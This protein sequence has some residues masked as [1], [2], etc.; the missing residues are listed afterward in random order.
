M[1][2]ISLAVITLVA[3]ESGAQSTTA[4]SAQSDSRMVIT[5][6]SLPE[7]YPHTPYNVRLVV[8]GGTAPWH[9]N[10]IRGAL[11][12]G[13]KLEEDGM[14]HGAAANGGDFQFTVLVRDSGGSRPLATKDFTLHVRSALSL[15]WKSVAHVD[16][17]R[18]EGSAEVSNTSPDDIDLTFIVMAVAA[19]GRA[20]A[21]GYQHF[22]LAKGTISQELPF[23]D[24][25]PPGAYVVHVDAVGEVE[26]KRYIYRERMQT[27]KPLHVTVG[28]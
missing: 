17:N 14:L 12:Q 2:C 25:L 5:T 7:A 21:I 3:A 28:P 23:G 16:G 27:P 6:D 13:I 4:S 26:A 19:N 18:I 10:V 22:S 24:T 15:N 8:T 20:T 1:T 9:W 11:P